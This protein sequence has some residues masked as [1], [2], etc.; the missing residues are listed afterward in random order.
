MGGYVFDQYLAT[1]SLRTSKFLILC[2]VSVQL[3]YSA[4]ETLHPNF[5]HNSQANHDLEN[6]QSMEWAKKTSVY[7]T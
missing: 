2:S 5:I 4:G 3:S 7:T 1:V 6:Y